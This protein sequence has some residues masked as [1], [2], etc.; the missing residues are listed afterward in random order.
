[1]NK[2]IYLI[3]LSISCFFIGCSASSPNEVNIPQ[4]NEITEL[5]EYP[6]LG[7]TNTFQESNQLPS[8]PEEAPQPKDGLASVSGVLFSFTS[9]ITLPGTLA[10]FTPALGEE[11]FFP[12]LL[13]GPNKDGGDYSFFSDTDANFFLRDIP[14]GN[15]Y[16]IVWGP[17]TWIPVINS[18]SLEP[19]LFQFSPDTKYNLGVLELAWP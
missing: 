7:I 12:A 1:M 15:Y 3:M 13:S 17:Y 11:K 4:Q 16:L 9:Q 2:I 19:V 10:Y 18:T 8:E 14:P 5:E 6:G